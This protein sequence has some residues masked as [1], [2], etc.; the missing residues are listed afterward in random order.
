VVHER[1]GLWRLSL[2]GGKGKDRP[3]FDSERLWN[4]QLQAARAQPWPQWIET[5]CNV[6]ALGAVLIGFTG[7]T[8][9]ALYRAMEGHNLVSTQLLAMA[10]VCLVLAG[11]YFFLD[12]RGNGEPIPIRERLMMVGLLLFPAL[13]WM[14][15]APMFNFLDKTIKVALQERVTFVVFGIFDLFGNP[16]VR[17]GSVLVLPTGRVGVEEACSGI[18]SL[19]ASLFAGSFLAS[20]CIRPGFD[21]LWKKVAMVGLAMAFAFFTNII[22]SLILTAWA[23]SHGPE[24][25]EEHMFV[26]GF[27]LGSMH[28]FLGYAVIVPVVIALRVLVP[29]FNFSFEIG[30]P[31]EHR[32][33]SQTAGNAKGKSSTETPKTS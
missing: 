5:V 1:W 12:R 16:I 24:A 11:G 22:R 23:Y 21:T 9:A 4:R 8:F 2:S 19:M 17:E 30:E 33:V 6:F 10:T 18:Y 7:V 32:K 13:I 28:D 20:T 3:R 14:L 29:L 31:V 27:D 15:S 25:I 26:F